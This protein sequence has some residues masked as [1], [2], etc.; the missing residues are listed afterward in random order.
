MQRAMFYCQ[1]V[2]GIGHLV[3]SSA[4]VQS[5]ARRFEVLFAVGGRV[6]SQFKFPDS[7]QVLRLPRL[8]M[9]AGLEHLLPCDSS[10]DLEQTKLRRQQELLQA[11]RSFQPDVLVTELFP[12]G[13]RQFAF[14]LEPLLELA[15]RGGSTLIV[16]SVRD[17]LVAKGDREKHERRAVKALN[18]YYDLVLVHSD[19]NFQKLEETFSRLPDVNCPV[20][21]TGYVTQLGAGSESRSVFAPDQRPLIVVSDGA[22]QCPSGHQLLRSAMRAAALLDKVIPH[23]FQFFAGLNMPDEVY[24][25][26]DA[27]ARSARN[28]Q[29]AHYTPSLPAV[30]R[31]AGLSISMA[32][33]STVMDVLCTGVRALV[34][35][36]VTGLEQEQSLRAAKL[37][38]RG[39]LGV[40]TPEDLA[41][42]R[43]ALEIQRALRRAPAP[44][45]LDLNGAENSARLLDE[46]ALRRANTQPL[47]RTAVG[48]A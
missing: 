16:S 43:L 13:R 21:Y 26:L 20:A 42:E 46:F 40:L 12:F 47:F 34:Y 32:G 44:L 22:G 9:D 35:P 3:R 4:V 1:Q 29:L 48:R 7:I 6:S 45:A 11:F 2:M 37:A 19:P 36:V 14:E 41:P 30:V 8:E 31:E 27:L 38:Q 18:R 17:I 25:E 15:R 5:L 28:V 23:R 24:A 39:V 10:L 33:Y